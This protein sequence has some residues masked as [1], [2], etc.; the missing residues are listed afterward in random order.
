MNKI[1]KFAILA[2]L[3]VLVFQAEPLLAGPGGAIVKGLFKTWWGKTILVLLTIIFLPLI[4]YSRI[5]EFFKIRKTKKALAFIGRKNKE[6]AWLNLQKNIKNV[7]TRTY[8]A[9]S[10]ENMAE[11]Q[12]YVSSWYW[13]NQQLVILDQ[14]KEQNLK[15]IC[16][17]RSI[18]SVKPLYLELTELEDFEHSKIAVE[19]TGSIKDYLI[20]RTTKKIIKGSKN[21]GDETHI[22]ILEYNNGN[23]LLDEIVN[24]DYSLVY[25]KTENI[26]PAN[27]QKAI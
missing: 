1:L 4:I 24:E 11:V 12:N 26:L 7:F 17:L 27:V 18:S 19:I 2:L 25:L 21:Y 3:L 14:W 6:F 5:I 22:W 9:W 8:L 15:N 10:N 23:W 20:D 13:Q 16:H